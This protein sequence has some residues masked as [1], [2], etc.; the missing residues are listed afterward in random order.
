MKDS[1]SASNI[2]KAH[3]IAAFSSY[4]LCEKK[5][6][7]VT[8]PSYDALAM[9]TTGVAWPSSLPSTFGSPTLT[10]S[11]QAQAASQVQSPCLVHA[12]NLDHSNDPWSRFRISTMRR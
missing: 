9:I 8:P 3:T 11:S 12:V 2:T 5:I 7:R 10:S 1:R 4:F 6:F